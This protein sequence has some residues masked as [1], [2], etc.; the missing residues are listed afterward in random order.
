MITCDKTDRNAS[1]EGEFNTAKR[2]IMKIEC[3]C[4]LRRSAS[5]SSQKPS[6]I[7]RHLGIFPRAFPGEKI[8]F[9]FM[10]QT[11]RDSRM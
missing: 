8:L 1:R 11:D 7:K 3:E 9:G 10:M 4:I 6:S 2:L 5:Q